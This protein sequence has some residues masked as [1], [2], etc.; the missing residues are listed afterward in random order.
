VKP[1][2]VVLTAAVYVATTIPY[3]Y[4]YLRQT[5][6]ARFTG[7]VFDV[8]DTAQYYAWM[9]AFSHDPLI[10]N[11]LTPEGGAERFF[12]LQWWLLGM[13][14]GGS[15]L[16][17]TL[18]YQGLRV[19]A[20]AAFAWLLAR[21]CRLV[22]G[23]QAFIA[24]ALVMLSSGLG[25][26]L[27]VAKQWSGELRWPLSVQIAEP[28]T[29]FSAMAFPHLL[30][31]SACMLA[32]YA[33]FL[34]SHASIP[35]P[36]VW[37]P[38]RPSW[39]R[40][41][42]LAGLTLALG[43]SHGYDLIPVVVVPVVFAAGQMLRARRL[44][45][46]LWP[47]AAICTG[48]ALPAAYTLSLTTLDATWDGVL[49][50]Y[51]NAGVYT[52]PIHQ[53]VI[54]LG[55][56]L[57]L[58]LPRLRPAEWRAASQPGQF[59]RCWF[60]VGFMLLYIPTD[61]QVKMLT[62]WQVPVCLLAAE[63]LTRMA[64]HVAQRRPRLRAT[65][66]APAV[67]LVVLGVMFLTNAYLTAWRITDLRRTEYPYFLTAGDMRALESLDGDEPSTVVLSSPELGVWVP[68]YSDA[69][70]FVAHWAQTLRFLERR[71]AAAWFFA[72]DT[73]DD[74]RLRFLQANGIAVVI[75]GPAEAGLAGGSAAPQ[76]DLER[77]VA[78]E[79]SVYVLHNEQAG[80]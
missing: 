46:S 4:G 50:Q 28:N 79:T 23:E 60:V 44:T 22:A 25:W 33:L 10:A 52:P 30:V 47:A 2:Y 45:P 41:A 42:A 76:L 51:G 35:T 62:G 38:V 57:L 74:E 12:N 72:E 9:R 40:L 77:I 55:L 31:A 69:R 21:F 24:F 75:A 17:A 67:P 6:Q 65:A 49:S 20:L 19:V 36:L 7:V 58:A 54:L 53:L 63:T 16:G 8:V 29:W 66:L 68:V 73:T 18:A 5:G 13:L 70:P 34:Q 48:A 26:M 3:V 80:R 56:P 14:S 1:R 59:V 78:G 11:P 15:P 43:F 39:S 71:D 64:Q 32:I 61:Y 27:V 37:L